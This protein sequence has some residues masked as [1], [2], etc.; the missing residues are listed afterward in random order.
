MST[1]TKVCRK[2]PENGEQPITNFHRRGNSFQNICKACRCATSRDGYRERGKSRKPRPIL[3]VNT[4]N[5]SELE[6]RIAALE[7]RLRATAA[8]FTYDA[9]ERDDIFSEMTAGIL[10]RCKPTDNDAFFMNCA[11]WTAQAFLAKK[12]TSTIYSENFDVTEDEYPV[13]VTRTTEDEII[14]HEALEQFRAVIATLPEKHQKIIAMLSIGKSQREIAHELKVSE[15][16]VS[17]RVKGLRA[18]L[19]SQLVTFSAF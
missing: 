2:C 10:L 8:R 13:D 7:P 11:K 4:T 17:D 14:Q 5:F 1:V 12:V 19:S 15:Q 3:E 18:Q 6:K 16:T 9:L